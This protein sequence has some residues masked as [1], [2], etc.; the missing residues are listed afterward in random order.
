MTR[1]LPCPHHEGAIYP[2]LSVGKGESRWYAYYTCPE[3]E[4]FCVGRDEVREFAIEFAADKWN[5][6]YE[7]TCTLRETH[8]DGERCSW[9]CICSICGHEFEHETGMTWNYCPH[10]GAKVVDE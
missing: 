8:W 9:G 1:L 4:W 6:R 7:P 3:C 10:C 2:L 5:K